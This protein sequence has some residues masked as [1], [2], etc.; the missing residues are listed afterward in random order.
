MNNPINT[1]EELFNYMGF[2]KPAVVANPNF[3]SVYEKREAYINDS[4]VEENE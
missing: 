1:T 4:E 3:V 2:G